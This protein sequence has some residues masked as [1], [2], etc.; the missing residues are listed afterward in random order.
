MT[1]L[2]TSNP[3]RK[4]QR[5]G[6]VLLLVLVILAIA[7]TVLAS[8]TR[9]NCNRALDA[10]RK[11][12]D[13]KRDWALRSAEQLLTDSAQRLLD[14][15]QR[16]ME[17]PVAR[18]SG[19][20]RLGGMDIRFLLSDEQAKANVNH[21]HYRQGA[22]DLALSIR[23]LQSASP[24]V[25]KVLLR[26]SRADPSLITPVPQIFSSYEQLYAIQRPEQL[27]DPTEGLEIAG[28]SV[29]C[30][31]SGRLQF[32]RAGRVV[33]RTQLAGL[34]N[35]TQIASLLDYIHENPDCSEKEALDAIEL[36][37]SAQQNS[38]IIRS[39]LEDMLTETSGCYG[40]WLQ[41]Q[42]EG[43]KWLRFIVSQS[44]DDRIDR[45]TWRFT[46]GD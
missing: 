13:L 28:K 24:K 12:R 43:R 21:L 39:V 34:L 22:G 35:E 38:Q 33:L 11:V 9:D 25:L 31:G 32:K 37:S 8:L 16:R 42:D 1:R 36:D 41:C 10:A 40:L 4:R 2:G 23:R 3:I 17:K 27:A 19:S 45:R 46:W 29:T 5:R 7:G 14:S 18:L 26:P 30:W 15:Q 6:F 44:A 20:I